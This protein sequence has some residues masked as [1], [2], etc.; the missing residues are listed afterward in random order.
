[1]PEV[2]LPRRMWAGG[3]L[4]SIAPLR[5]C[6]AAQLHSQVAGVQHKSGRSGQMVFVT[7]EHEIRCGDELRLREAHDI[8]YREAPAS[9]AHRP[10]GAMAQ[11][12]AKFERTVV[13][14]PVMLFVYLALSFNGHRIHYD[15]DY[16]RQVEH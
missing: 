9:G 10:P 15:R 14:D 8:F 11:V 4:Q 2:S 16:C 3:R 12:D 7:V 6:D 5:I 13:P 1:M